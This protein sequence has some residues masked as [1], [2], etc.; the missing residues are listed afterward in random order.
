MDRAIPPQA[1]VRQWVLSLPYRLR[2]LCAYDADACSLVR[3]VLVRAVSG[4][5]EGRAQRCGVSRPRTGAVAFVQRF[6]S[7]LRLN[8]HFHVLW[9]DGAYGHEVGRGAVRWREH[10]ELADKDVASLVRR[11]RDRVVKALR[12]EGKWWDGDDAAEG[13][14]D[15]RD[16]ERLLL[17]VSSG[18][19]VGRAVLGE[20]SGS[21]DVRVD[22]GTRH[23]PFVK[24]PLC[25]DCD[26][27]SLHAECGFRPEIVA[28]SSTWRA[29]RVVR[30]S[31]R[32]GSCC[33]RMGGLRMRSRSGGR[34]ARRRW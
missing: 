5:Y 13:E 20:H 1:P 8:V 9:L 6:D 34:T 24:G 3:R 33:W 31:R 7:G 23:E 25:A 22:R 21:A 11:V 30:R 17:E 29:T 2:L 27:F 19:V 16:E 32:R 15:C 10:E 4:F 12:R 14:A 18:A 28:V 26:G